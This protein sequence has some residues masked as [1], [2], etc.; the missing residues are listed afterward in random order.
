MMRYGAI[1]SIEY[2]IDVLKELKAKGYSSTRLRGEKILGEATIQRLRKKQSVSFDVLAKI[3]N[4]LD[5]QIEDVL[6]YSP[7]ET[8]TRNNPSTDTDK[9]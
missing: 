7:L 4:M 9:C 8:N 3:C 5:C 1:M 2:R 6:V